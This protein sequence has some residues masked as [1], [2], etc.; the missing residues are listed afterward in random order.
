MVFC[1]VGI[2]IFGILGIFSAKYRTYAK[3][4]LSCILDAIRLRPCEMNFDEK[5][6]A[7]LVAR[8][9]LKFPRAGNFV[10]K[11]FMLI[12][13][14]LLV[15][16][17]ASIAAIGIGVYN[18]ILYGNCNGA[19]STDFCVLGVLGSGSFD[20]RVA[21]LKSVAPDDGPTLGNPNASV[22]IVEVGCFICPYTR[23]AESFRKQLLAKYQ[24]NVSFTFRTMPLPEH[25]LSWST[26]EAAQCAR[27]QNKYWEYHDKLFAEQDN[28]SIETI[29]AIAPELNLNETQF[30]RC[31]EMH[32]YLPVVQKDSDDAIAAGVFATPTY[33]IDGKPV[34][35]IKAFAALEQIVIGEIRG[36][37]G[38]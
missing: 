30:A 10:H 17:I 23:D 37:C 34:V 26:A 25:N 9:G 8:I 15:I 24:N 38:M 14:I 20:E 7:M 5:M 3:Q 32:K 6:R 1:L 28:M 27:E 16:T 33:F 35:G 11:H 4:S 2:I 12:S 31:M 19:T 36:T 21:Q 18:Y 29:Y 22:Q 13:W